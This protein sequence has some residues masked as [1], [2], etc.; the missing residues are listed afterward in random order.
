MCQSGS[1]GLSVK[2]WG[3]CEQPVPSLNGTFTSLFVVSWSGPHVELA[4]YSRIT[5]HFTL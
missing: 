3:E 1:T 2:G 4:V 5:I